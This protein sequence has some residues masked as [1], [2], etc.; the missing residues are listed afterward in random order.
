MLVIIVSVEGGRIEAIEPD[1]H[2]MVKNIRLHGDAAGSAHTP[3]S[4]TIETCLVAVFDKAD[5]TVPIGD[6]GLTFDIVYPT[7]IHCFHH[8]DG[9]IH[10]ILTNTII[11]I[12]Y[13]VEGE[14]EVS[15]E[16]LVILLGELVGYFGV[17]LISL[18]LPSGDEIFIKGQ[19]TWVF[20]F[21]GT[22]F[23]PGWF[24]CQFKIFL[25]CHNNDILV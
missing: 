12:E 11:L 24:A 17:L 25:T 3:G 23:M 1:R 4:T 9:L 15:I 22:A 10:I 14:L 13:V 21:V 19:K 5:E 8:G 7:P 20:P 6:G 16:H 18:T 2:K